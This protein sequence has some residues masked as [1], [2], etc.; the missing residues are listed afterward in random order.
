MSDNF[1]TGTEIELAA[2]PKLGSEKADRS[3]ADRVDKQMSLAGLPCR[4][5]KQL[6]GVVGREVERRAD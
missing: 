1:F 2:A 4:N 6:P 5:R 3:S